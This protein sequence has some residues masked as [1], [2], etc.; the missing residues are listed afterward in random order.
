MK[1]SNI[2][3]TLLLLAL[4][5]HHLSSIAEE[6]LEAQDIQPRPINADPNSISEVWLNAGFYSYHF[7]K[8]QNLNNNNIGLGVEYRYSPSSALSVGS[9][10]NSDRKN[11]LYAAVVWEPLTLLSFRLGGLIGVING[12]PRANNGEWIAVILPT[13]SYEHKNFG[14]NITIVPQYKDII[15]GTIS[16]QLKFRMY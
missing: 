9:Y 15:Y 8:S 14:F 3:A 6:V 5:L 12:Y 13:A 10:Y 1:P 2:L 16:I 11:S 7:D 4:T